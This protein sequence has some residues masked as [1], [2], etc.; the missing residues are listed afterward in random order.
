[1]RFASLGSGSRGNAT[2]V[3]AG[4]TLLLVDCGFSKKEVEARLARLGETATQ[5]DAILVTHEHGDHC[6]GVAP[7]ARHYNI[8]VYLSHG[9]AYFERL[10]GNFRQ[11]LINAGDKFRIGDVEVSAVPVPHD[12]REP[13][14]FCFRYAN[15]QLGLLTDLG[16]ITPHVIDSFGYC[17]GLLLEF[18]H[19]FDLLMQGPYPTSL[20][21]RVA[22]DFGHLN[23]VQSVEFIRQ[24]NMSRLQALAVGHLSPQNNTPEHVCRALDSVAEYHSANVTIASQSMGFNWVELTEN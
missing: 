14:Q 12:A 6:S 18:N 8:P 10:N 15:Q 3:E 16:S 5:I 2:L 11:V 22:S 1:M 19:D 7:L 23:N 4:N 24:A 21:H 17:T 20:K 13:V 9:T